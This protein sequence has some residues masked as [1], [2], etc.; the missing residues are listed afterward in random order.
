MT[1]IQEIKNKLHEYLPTLKQKYPIAS[2]ALF[3]SVVRDDFDTEK[4]DID[5]LVEFN[6]PIG[7]QFIDIEEELEELLGRKVDLISKDSLTK[8]WW[9]EHILKQAV[10]V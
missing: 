9:R 2:L 5:I 7:W 1:A 8:P 6:G 3:G 4:S 10:N